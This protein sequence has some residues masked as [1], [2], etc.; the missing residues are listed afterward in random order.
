LA[1]A[2]HPTGICRAVC[3]SFAGANAEFSVCAMVVRR[4]RQL[5]IFHS[6]S[7]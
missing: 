3:F 4:P 2:A 5:K 6:V 7:G 1:Q